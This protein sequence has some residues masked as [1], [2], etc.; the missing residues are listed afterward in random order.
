[1][2]KKEL[3]SEVKSLLWVIGNQSEKVYGHL[4]SLIERLYPDYSEEQR[5]EITK[6]IMSKFK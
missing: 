4:R 5:A 6:T 2:D 3:E 1:M